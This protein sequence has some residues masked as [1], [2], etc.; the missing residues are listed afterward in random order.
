MFIIGLS[1]RFFTVPETPQNTQL[2]F[3][4][5]QPEDSGVYTCYVGPETNSITI[6]IEG[7][8]TSYVY[9]FFTSKCRDF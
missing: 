7:K 6:I 1:E 2:V 9:L 3:P 4:D 5:I 8:F